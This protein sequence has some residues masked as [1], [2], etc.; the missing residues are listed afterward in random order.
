[1][2]ARNLRITGSGSSPGGAY[3]KVTVIG[4]GTVSGEIDCFTCKTQGTSQLSG[5]VKC[6]SFHVS[7]TSNVKGK[8]MAERIKIYGETKVTGDVKVTEAKIRGSVETKA[9]LFAEMIDL[10]GNIS[11][12]KDCEVETLTGKGGFGVDGL[13]NV[14]NLQLKMSFPS[15]AKEIGGEKIHIRRD[16]FPFGINKSGTLETE[17]IEGDDIE[18]EQTTAKIVRG[19]RVKVG[20]GCKIDLVEYK[21]HLEID[22]D[23]LVIEQVQI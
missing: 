21:D 13:L 20:P 22:Q 1:M 10:R 4:E 8:L 12:K 6:D 9:G 5:N 23:A 15:K 11:A 19:N 16:R 7:G 3:E 18:L 17:S 2:E 14:G